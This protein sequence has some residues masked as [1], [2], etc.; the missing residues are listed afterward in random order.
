MLF[1]VFVIEWAFKKANRLHWILNFSS[2][3][4]NV[5]LKKMRQ[6]RLALIS[7]MR[8]LII[9]LHVDINAFGQ[10]NKSL[11]YEIFNRAVV[12]RFYEAWIGGKMGRNGPKLR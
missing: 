9:T 1:Q 5:F 4:F 11:I 10:D 6:S 8:S 3:I 12:L 7:L 2:E